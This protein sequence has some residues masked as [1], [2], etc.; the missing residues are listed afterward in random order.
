MKKFVLRTVYAFMFFCERVQSSHSFFLV[1]ICFIILN[2]ILLK[3]LQYRSSDF[4][5]QIEFV[6]Q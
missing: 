1:F 3:K 2:V 4:V 5:F 6:K